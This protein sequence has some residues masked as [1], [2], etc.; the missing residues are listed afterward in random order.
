ME[1]GMY[2]NLGLALVCATGLSLATAAEAGDL[3]VLDDA[4]LDGVTAAGFV[5]FETDVL[6]TVDLAVTID[7]I[8]TVAVFSVVDVFGLFAT[9]EASADCVFYSNC[10]AETETFAQVAENAAYAF[11]LSTAAA[12]PFGGL[13]PVPVEPTVAP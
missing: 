2:R 13:P 6:K 4:G 3:L 9:A 11:S 8:K 7:F 12:D 5:A 1:N 10:L